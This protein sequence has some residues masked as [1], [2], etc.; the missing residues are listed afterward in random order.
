MERT[1]E[2]NCRSKN[3]FKIE[4]RFLVPNNLRLKKAFIAMKGSAVLADEQR[5]PRENT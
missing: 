3:S 5:N 4:T 2:S 1:A